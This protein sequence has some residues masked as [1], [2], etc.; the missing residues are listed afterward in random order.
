MKRVLA[1][2]AALIM[3]GGALAIRSGGD[4]DDGDAAAPS[5]NDTATEAG[6]GTLTIGCVAELLA[7]CQKAFDQVTDVDPDGALA[8]AQAGEIDAWVTLEPWPE[9]AQVELDPEQPVF[10]RPAGLGQQEIVLAVDADRRAA[11]ATAC[12]D[13]PDW[14]CVVSNAGAAWSDLDPASGL[15]GSFRLGLGD[16]SS[17]LGRLL[18]GHVVGATTTLNDE[19]IDAADLD[20]IEEALAS[21]DPGPTS[22][23]LTR[24]ATTG[25][26]QYSAVVALQAPAAQVAGSQQGEQRRLEV[27]P[28]GPTGTVR[29]VLAP[30][31]GGDDV[32]SERAALVE[33]LAD[34]GW[35]PATT[36]ATDLPDADLL[37]ALGARLSR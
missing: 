13:E 7:A 24:L 1:L 35:S 21:A 34:A 5:G 4:G 3:I 10:G 11:L 16:R 18:V 36:E 33:A 29:A 19:G 28:V 2:V 17:A 27:V 37:V 23:Q 6:N 25:P 14:A 22:A 8:A 32:G 31:L 15:Q 26:G 20:P 30:V 12:S 9:M